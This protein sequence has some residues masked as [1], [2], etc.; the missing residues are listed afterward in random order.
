MYE[1]HPG[2]MGFSDLPWWQGGAHMMCEWQ[3]PEDKSRE[4]CF[5]ETPE[6]ETIAQGAGCVRFQQSGPYPLTCTG[7]DGREGRYWCCPENQP[8][9][10][11]QNVPPDALVHDEERQRLLAQEPEVPNRE[12]PNPVPQDASSIGGMHPGAVAAIGVAV[13]VAYLGYHR[14]VSQ[15][16]RGADV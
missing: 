12:K 4:V 16:S 14:F 10:Y 11:M 5:Q 3:P 6:E 1:V 15:E 13:V 7:A 8:R 9:D 2:A